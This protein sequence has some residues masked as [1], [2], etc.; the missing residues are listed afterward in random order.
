MNVLIT[1]IIIGICLSMDAFSFALVY[2]TYG[3]NLKKQI[4]LSIIVSL[5]HFFM[6]VIGHLFGSLIINSFIFNSNLIVGI[7]FTIIGIDMILS[8]NK[9]EDYGF[10][11]SIYGYLLF[12]FTVSIDSFTVGV[13]ITAITEYYLFFSSVFM[14]FSG[15][16]TYLGLKL[17][18]IINKKFGKYGCFVSGIVMMVLGICYI[19][20]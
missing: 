10:I 8:F 20:N 5:F 11:D 17:G 3:F 2:G 1:A 14:I 12:G 13:G 15:M 4:F 16:F 6:P 19:F 9:D 7:I 18:N